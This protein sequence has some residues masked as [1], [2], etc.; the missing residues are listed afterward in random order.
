MGK[1]HYLKV[2]PNS[3][4]EDRLME[5]LKKVDAKPEAI[6]CRLGAIFGKNYNEYLISDGLFNQIKD[7]LTQNEETRA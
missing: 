6:I 1:I 3:E 7:Y 2:E 5:L 4:A